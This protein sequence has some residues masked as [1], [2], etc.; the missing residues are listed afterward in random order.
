[1]LFVVVVPEVVQI[2]SRT[3]EFFIQ[4]LY[5]THSVTVSYCLQRKKKT[6]FFNIKKKRT[7]LLGPPCISF[8][9]NDVIIMLNYVL[10]ERVSRKTKTT[11]VKWRRVFSTLKV[12]V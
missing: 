6:F 5:F 11:L 2:S 4:R 7:Q 3:L 1:M 10:S 9:I 12:D 8:W